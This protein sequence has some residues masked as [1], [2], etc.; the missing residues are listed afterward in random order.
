[1]KDIDYTKREISDGSIVKIY[2]SNKPER[3]EGETFIEYKL[4]LTAMKTYYKA[5]KNKLI[6][7]SSKQGT[8]NQANF[9]QFV[10]NIENGK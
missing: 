6:W 9:K 5:N 1:M 7:N 4:R 8:L 3:L 10:N 2:H